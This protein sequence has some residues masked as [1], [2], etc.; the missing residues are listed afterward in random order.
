MEKLS[1]EL[2]QANRQAVSGADFI[3]KAGKVV[4]FA[5]DKVRLDK[6]LCLGRKVAVFS[7]DLG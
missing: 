5:A 2:V 4:I 7:P 6:L 3:A 1:F